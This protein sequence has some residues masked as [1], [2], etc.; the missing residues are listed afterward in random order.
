MTGEIRRDCAV[1]FF[2]LQQYNGV[3]LITPLR[4][5]TYSHCAFATDASDG[6]FAAVLNDHWFQAR[7][8]ADWHGVHINLQEFVPVLLALHVWGELW[9]HAVFTFHCDNRAVVDVLRSNTSRDPGMLSVLRAIL[10]FSLPRDLIV[11]AIHLPG[12]LNIVADSLSRFQAT[13][14]FLT[15]HNLCA[16]PTKIPLQILSSIVH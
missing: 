3:S 6:G 8:P 10:A 4:D 5:I 9:S 14:S 1:W 12:K 16:S 11:H 7:W 2:F 15:E 13:N